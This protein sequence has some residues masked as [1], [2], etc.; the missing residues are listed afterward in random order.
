[1]RMI[2]Y[3]LSN[4]LFA[5]LMFVGLFFYMIPIVIRRGRISGSAYEPF[6]ARLVWHLIGVRPDTATLKL[7]TV[8]PATNPFSMWLLVRPLAW[9]SL[10]SGFVPAA[11]EFPPRRPLKL[12]SLIT[13]RTEFL[14]AALRDHV[15]AGDQVVIL[16]AGWDTRAWGSLANRGVQVW[17]V[18]AP[19]TQAAKQAAVD[20]AGL[21]ASAVEFVAC[22]FNRQNWLEALKQHGFSQDRRTFV[23]WEGVSMYLD[24]AAIRETFET[25]ASLPA[26]SR[27]ACDFLAEEWLSGGFIGALVKFGGG[28]AYGERFRSG[29]PTMPGFES[30][31][32]VYLGSCGLNLEAAW[33]TGDPGAEQSPFWGLLVA[34]R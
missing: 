5:P 23:L 29:L 34:R 16:G 2:F 20:G 30:A 9:A 13:A 10:M 22:D 7:S 18:D 8:M 19:A 28:L 15:E 12:P 11:L 31:L 3:A 25:V 21:D 27:I 4:L 1:M 17:E 24:A 26:G 33:R 14:D 32:T 6:S